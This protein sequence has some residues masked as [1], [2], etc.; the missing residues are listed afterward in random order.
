MQ[1]ALVAVAG[2]LWPSNLSYYTIKLAIVL[3]RALNR[4]IASDGATDICFTL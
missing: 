2:L 1:A 3:R 4:Q